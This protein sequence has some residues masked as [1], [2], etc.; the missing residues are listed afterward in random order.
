MVK[1]KVTVRGTA[2]LNG[3]V[4]INKS[5]ITDDARLARSFSGG[6][7]Y[8]VIEAWVRNNYPGVNIPNIRSFSANIMSFEEKKEKS[9]KS[10]GKYSKGKEGLL[11]GLLSKPTESA[12]NFI[13]NGKSKIWNSIKDSISAEFLGEDEEN[14]ILGPDEEPND[15]QAGVFN[16]M[17]QNASEKLDNL[18]DSFSAGYNRLAKNSNKFKKNTS[19]KLDNVGGAISDTYSDIAKSTGQYYDAGNAQ[20]SELGLLAK[21]QL[22]DANGTLVEF[23][24]GLSNRYEALEIKDGLLKLVSNMDSKAVILALDQ[25]ETNDPKTKL[26][27][28]IIKKILIRLDKHNTLMLEESSDSLSN[29]LNQDIFNLTNSINLKNALTIAEPFVQLI[30]YGPTALYIIGLFI[31][32]SVN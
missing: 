13:S 20:L 6:D 16:K 5:F 24:T 11:S 27:I 23:K 25:A 2:Q 10:N 4:P 26:A 29:Q 19:S 12:S 28:S 3:P 31:K 22:N 15:E 32:D 8:Q 21:K 9:A 17:K 18:G 30:P 14:D 1:Y 7:R